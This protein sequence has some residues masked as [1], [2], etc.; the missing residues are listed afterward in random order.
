MEVKARGLQTPTQVL[1]CLANIECCRRSMLSWH[2]ACLLFAAILTPFQHRTA[3]AVLHNVW[4]PLGFEPG[5][6]WQLVAGHPFRWGSWAFGS[7]DEEKSMV[8]GACRWVWSSR[9]PLANRAKYLSGKW[10][11]PVKQLAPGSAPRPPSFGTSRTEVLA[12]LGPTSPFAA[13]ALSRPA[14]AKFRVRGEHLETLSPVKAVESYV[15]TSPFRKYITIAKAHLP[16]QSFHQTNPDTHSPSNPPRLFN[17]PKCA[18]PPP[19]PSTLLTLLLATAIT[20]LHAVQITA[21]TKDARVDFAKGVTVRWT[22]VATDPSAARLVLVNMAAGHTPFRRALADSIDLSLGSVIVA[23][24]A[25]VQ[26]EGGYQFN[27]ESVEEGNLGGILAQS[28]Q[29]RVVKAA[30]EGEEEEGETGVVGTATVTISSTTRGGQTAATTATTM[31]TGTKTVDVGGDAE[32]TGDSSSSSSDGSAAS[33]SNKPASKTATAESSASAS[34]GA[35]KDGEKKKDEES[36]ASRAKVAGGLMA[37]LAGAV[38][39]MA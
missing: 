34:A 25:G 13:A 6:S 2:M 38:A 22:A 10:H 9:G 37:V 26:A 11:A 32:A 19:S 33:V 36:G 4:Q 15:G 30:V 20:P 14:D 7:S 35:E 8:W 16:I 21:P 17:R 24:Q 27:F 28:A 31:L 23:P 5:V 29:F 12:W 18:A 1:G 39:V 3:G